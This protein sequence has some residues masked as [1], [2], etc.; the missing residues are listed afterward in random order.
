MGSS[1]VGATALTGAGVLSS[2]VRS[3]TSS[4]PSMSQRMPEL[5]MVFTVRLSWIGEIDALD[6][7]EGK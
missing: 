3:T 7:S 1:A 5:L 6:C 4:Q 2:V